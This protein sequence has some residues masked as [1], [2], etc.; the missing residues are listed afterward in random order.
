MG[1]IT[2]GKTS[3]VSKKVGKVEKR[4]GKNLGKG[5]KPTNTRKAK[6]SLKGTNPL[7][8]KFAITWSKDL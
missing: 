5:S 1:K 8:K 4:Y 7:K 6:V 3:T 2:F